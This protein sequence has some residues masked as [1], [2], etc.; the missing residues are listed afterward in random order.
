MRHALSM[1]ALGGGMHR[2]A[3]LDGWRGCAVLS[4]LLAHFG[5]THLINLGR[6]GVE[7][8]FVLSGRLMAEILFE[9]ETPLSRFFPRRFSRVY[10][11]L[12]V[13]LCLLFATAAWRGGDPTLAQY[14]GAVTFTANYAQFWTGRSAVLDHIWSLCI[15]EHMYVLL[16]LIAFVNRRRRLPVVAICAGL[17]AIAIGIGVV[18]TVAGYGYYDV[19]WRTDVRGASLLLGVIAYMIFNEQPPARLSWTWTPLLFGAL[20]L[21]LNMNAVPDPVKYSLGT[22]LL[23]LSLVLMPRAPAFA[24]RM[25][26]HPLLMRVG[27]WSYSIYLWQQPLAKFDGSLWLRPIHLAVAII[28]ALIS[29]HGIEQPARRLLNR[30]AA[31]RHTSI[32]GQLVMST[33]PP[34]ASVLRPSSNCEMPSTHHSGDNM[35]KNPTAKKSSETAPA[36]TS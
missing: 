35:A 24:L 20:A 15:E 13:F 8:F 1:E 5:T 4:V 29:F 30:L 27:I 32:L 11:A 9:R 23:A 2:V 19:Y 36:K 12:F 31:A 6:F 17:A 22:A 16:G 33:I 10:P 14:L 21:I 18:Q 26:E 28:L 25:L 7:L 34:I 3:Y